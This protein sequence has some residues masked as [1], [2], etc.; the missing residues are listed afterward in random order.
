MGKKNK[1]P[2]ATQVEK[3]WNEKEP[4]QYEPHHW[5]QQQYFTSCAKCGLIRLRNQLTDWSIDKGCNF[6]DHGQFRKMVDQYTKKDNYLDLSK[7]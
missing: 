7:Y 4:Y 1:Q 6:S 3:A 5:F 2:Q